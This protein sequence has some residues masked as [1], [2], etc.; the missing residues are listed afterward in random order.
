MEICTSVCYCNEDVFIYTNA[1]SGTVVEECAKTGYVLTKSKES[2]IAI[3][4]GGQKP[5]NYRKIVHKEKATGFDLTIC[6]T[7]MK[8]MEIN[9]KLFHNKQSNKLKSFLEYP[10]HSINRNYLLWYIKTQK[11]IEEDLIHK[12]MEKVKVIDSMLLQRLKSILISFPNNPSYSHINEMVQF[13]EKYTFTPS[14]FLNDIL[15]KIHKGSGGNTVSEPKVRAEMHISEPKVRAEMHISEDVKYMIDFYK[16]SKGFYEYLM[17]NGL[18]YVPPVF[19][20]NVHDKELAVKSPENK[21]PE[22]KKGFEMPPLLLDDTNNQG[23]S[24]QKNDDEGMFESESEIEDSGDT[25]EEDTSGDS[26]GTSDDENEMSDYNK[27]DSSDESDS[28][29]Y[30]EDIEKNASSKGGD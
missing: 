6:T 5:C 27:S 23:N 21:I 24:R 14:K 22:P 20:D 29:E 30:E 7:A 15:E 16:W 10:N 17:K 28:E 26:E 1:S 3:K 9:T 19:I 12:T 13:F 4:K 18:C 11:E 2:R 25:S 8:K